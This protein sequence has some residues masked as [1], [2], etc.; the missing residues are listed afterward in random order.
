MK[1]TSF[2]IPPLHASKVPSGGNSEGKP[3]W[4]LVKIRNSMKKCQKLLV[5]CKA[6]ILVRVLLLPTKSQIFFVST[7]RLFFTAFLVN[8]RLITKV[9]H[10]LSDFSITKRF[11][12]TFQR[13]CFLK[14]RNA[15][16]IEP[17]SEMKK[18]F[19]HA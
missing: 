6:F 3:P 4:I 11:F 13:S 15:V 2:T 18:Y 8:S 12:A 5:K 19:S 9:F 16:N 10:S 17:Q 1:I 7:S 14:F